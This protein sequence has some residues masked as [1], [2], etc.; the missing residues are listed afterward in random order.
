MGL[1]EIGVFSGVGDEGFDVVFVI[2]E[3]VGVVFEDFCVMMMYL[4]EVCID[5]CWIFV[6]GMCCD[7]VI[8]VICFQGGLVVSCWL[9][10]DL[11]VGDEVVVGNVGLRMCL[12]QFQ[13][14]FYEILFGLEQVFSEYVVV[15][16]EQIVWWLYCLCE[17]G[18]KIVVMVGFGVI[19]IGGGQQFVCLIQCG[20]VNWLFVG[21]VFVVYD[22]EC[23]MKGFEFCIL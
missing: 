1:I 11:V 15:V 7:V 13:C 19:C 14:G 3:Q 12:V 18:G 23:V 21:N 20:Y 16:V 10:C 2:V 6:V 9:L 22:M 4:M 17:Q 8:Q 5:G